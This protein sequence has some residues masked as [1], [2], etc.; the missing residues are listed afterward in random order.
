MPAWRRPSAW[1]AATAVAEPPEE[2]PGTRVRSQ[3]LRVSPSA[4]FSV[5]EPIANSSMLSLPTRTAPARPSR[6]ASV[7]S[8]RGRKPARTR[9]AQVVA[10]SLVMNRSFS[11]MGMP[12]RVPS[13][14][15][16]PRRLSDAAAWARASSPGTSRKLPIDWSVAAM[17][18]RQHSVSSAELSWPVRSSSAASSMRNSLVSGTVSAAIR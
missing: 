11:P 10:T 12:S 5:D 17:R 14:S 8:K 1:R 16:S 9:E 18:A 15:P 4:E 3:G 6:S 2:P 7:P 13:V